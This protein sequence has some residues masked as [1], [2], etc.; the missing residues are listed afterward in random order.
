MMAYVKGGL[1]RAS[2]N[3]AATRNR[4]RHRSASVK[5]RGPMAPDGRRDPVAAD[6]LELS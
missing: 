4:I 1:L 6:P 3:A 5:Y 2:G